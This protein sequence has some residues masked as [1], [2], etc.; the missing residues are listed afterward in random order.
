MDANNG[1]ENKG[2]D[3]HRTYIWEFWLQLYSYYSFISFLVTANC[4]LTC[5]ATKADKQWTWLDA[6]HYI[7]TIVQQ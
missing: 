6:E 2:I 4:S 7:E 1:L 5:H 3:P